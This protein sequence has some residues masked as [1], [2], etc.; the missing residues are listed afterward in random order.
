M[1]VPLE[2]RLLRKKVPGIVQCLPILYNQWYRRA[3]RRLLRDRTRDEVEQE[4]RLAGIPGYVAEVVTAT[5]RDE[6]CWPDGALFVPADECFVLFCWW[7]LALS[8]G[9]EL[10]LCILQIERELRVEITDELITRLP[11][12]K[13]GDL[14]RAIS[15]G[16]AVVGL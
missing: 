11:T 13:L 15:G 4:W 8:D 3:C 6:Y 16:P 2:H 7:R 12:L 9:L 1:I 5:V 14:C 10:P